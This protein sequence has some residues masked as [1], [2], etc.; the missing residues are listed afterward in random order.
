MNDFLSEKLIRTVNQFVCKTGHECSM[1]SSTF[2]RGH[3]VGLPG[4]DNVLGF[5]LVCLV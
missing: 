4:A 1:Q 3:E 5:D 2:A